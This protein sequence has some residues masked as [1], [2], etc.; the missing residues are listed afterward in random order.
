MNEYL[1]FIIAIEITIK[2][3]LFIFH[4]T[5]VHR[6]PYFYFDALPKYPLI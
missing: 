1:T 5:C 4:P 3:F 2:L 6:L